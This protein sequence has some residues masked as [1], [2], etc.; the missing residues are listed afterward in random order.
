MWGASTKT[1]QNRW[2][3]GRH[4]FDLFAMILQL[5]QLS[6]T[7]IQGLTVRL[8][9]TDHRS[10]F[11]MKFLL[12]PSSVESRSPARRDTWIVALSQLALDT[13]TNTHKPSAL[14]KQSQSNLIT[15]FPIPFQSAMCLQP[16]YRDAIGIRTFAS[17]ILPALFL[18]Q[19][20]QSVLLTTDADTLAI[21]LPDS[22][23]HP[24][25]QC[26]CAE[27]ICALLIV[28]Y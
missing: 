16:A 25:I 1:A 28:F 24:P 19:F 20:W 27:W 22:W 13:R 4:H 11:E 17:L 14:L 6:N 9:L 10:C 2:P 23:Q 21:P 8:R 7:R 18:S 15:I 3:Q 12:L 5:P 26:L